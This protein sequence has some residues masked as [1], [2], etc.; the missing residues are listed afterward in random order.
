M[1]EKLEDTHKHKAD[2]NLDVKIILRQFIS[3]KN[4]QKQHYLG[5]LLQ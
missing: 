3:K 4:E 5:K 2:D 1:E